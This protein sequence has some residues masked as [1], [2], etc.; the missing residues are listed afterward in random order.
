MILYLKVG[1]VHSNGLRRLVDE[2]RKPDSDLHCRVV[3]VDER[4]AA[5]REAMDYL[6]RGGVEQC[7]AFFTPWDGW[8]VGH[9]EVMEFLKHHLV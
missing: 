3:D 9:R 1:S 2:A 4:T 6:Y 8:I 5:G 7:P